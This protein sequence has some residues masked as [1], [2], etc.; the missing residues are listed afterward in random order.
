M[1]IKVTEEKHKLK[2]THKERQARITNEEEDNREAEANNKLSKQMVDHIK[3]E[4]AT[5]AKM[6]F[7]SYTKISR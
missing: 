5:H 3:K 1:R 4:A 7:G 2:E 6:M